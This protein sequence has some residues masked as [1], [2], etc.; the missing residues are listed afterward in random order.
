MFEFHE[1]I[2]GELRPRVSVFL[3]KSS[4]NSRL[5]R[6]KILLVLFI[7]SKR[8]HGFGFKAAVIQPG[9]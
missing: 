5:L 2:L 9:P 4:R 1:A 8:I 6:K 7:L 3:S